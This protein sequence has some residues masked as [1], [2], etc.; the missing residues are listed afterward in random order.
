MAHLSITAIAV[1]LGAMTLIAPIATAQP[2]AASQM[3]RRGNAPQCIYTYAWDSGA[4]SHQRA[5][6]TC[7]GP[8]RIKLVWKV[9][10]T[11]CQTLLT[12]QT[13]ESAVL[14]PAWAQGADIC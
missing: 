8:T 13:M 5:R 9:S 1:S 3:P 7:P 6:S 11:H 10:A 4:Y 2:A 12:G 14:R